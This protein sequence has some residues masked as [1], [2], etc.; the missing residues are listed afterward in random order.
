M[1]KN[2]ISVD[3]LIVGSGPSGCS[4]ALH[5]VKNNPEWVGRVVVLEKAVHP[6]KKLCGGG[7]TKFAESILNK[8]G[9]PIEPANFEIKEVRLVYENQ[10]YSFYDDPILRIVQ[11]DE[12]DQWLVKKAELLGVQVRQGEAV[13]QITQLNDYVEVI[14]EKAIFHAKVLVGADGAFGI[15]RRALKWNDNP[16]VARLLEVSTP[17]N[18]KIQAEFCDRVAIF[19]FT[20]MTTEDLQ[21]YYWDFPK[22]TKGKAYMSRGVYDSRVRPERHKANLKKTLHDSMA[23]RGR[24]LADHKLAGYPIRW[25]S[26]NGRFSSPRII[27]VGDAAGT[28]P[29]LGEGITFAL[30]YGLVAS[31]AI[32]D[33]FARNDFSFSN[34]KKMISKNPLFIQLRIRA[35]IAR[36]IYMIKYP[37]L[38]R[39]GWYIGWHNITWIVALIS[40]LNKIPDSL[41]RSKL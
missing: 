13:K 4:T 17:E 14:T 6:R 32:N 33:A 19:D 7:V 28:D 8:L 37:W 15:V 16:Q 31:L 20:R 30:G 40:W 24:D 26:S 21:G 25:W 3:V 39:L 12:F 41:R 35:R 1:S 29:L 9:L 38:L 34:Y 23:E 27:L 10:T 18:A 22:I 36:F 5:L 11:R 2:P